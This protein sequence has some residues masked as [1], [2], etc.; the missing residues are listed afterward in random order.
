MDTILCPELK[1]PRGM[2]EPLRAQANFEDPAPDKGLKPSAL[3]GRIS[4]LPSKW[5][6]PIPI[7]S[8]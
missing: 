6:D 5:L 4:L 3:Y 7:G 1:L 2:V 8:V